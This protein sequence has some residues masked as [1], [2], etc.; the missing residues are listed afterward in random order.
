MTTTKLGAIQKAGEPS[1][2]PPTRLSKFLASGSR[3]ENVTLPLLGPAWIELAGHETTTRVESET[4][5]AMARLALEPNMLNALTYDAERARRTLADV[6]REQDDHAKVFGTVAEWGRVD[7]DII[8]ACWNI[9]AD[10]RYRLDPVGA[11][12]TKED[13]T[14]IRAFLEKKNAMG[15]RS[16]GVAKLALFMLT[17]ASPPENSQTLSSSSSPLSEDSSTSE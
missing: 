2:A 17:S 15:L 14:G 16:Y 7:P 9:Y 3:G 13:E 5:D 11:E 8:A 6:V 4:F 1:G 12:L 10:V